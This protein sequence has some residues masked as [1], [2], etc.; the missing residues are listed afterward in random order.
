MFFYGGGTEVP[1]KVK[2]S[3]NEKRED[4]ILPFIKSDRQY[5]CPTM[6]LI[7]LLI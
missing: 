5:Y 7:L 6:S 3:F 4:K 2:Y 1:E